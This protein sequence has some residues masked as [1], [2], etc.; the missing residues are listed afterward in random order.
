MIRLATHPALAAHRPQIML[1]TPP[2]ID[3]RL[4]EICDREKGINVTRRTAVNTAR[5]AQTVRD[6]G[7]ELDLPVLDIWS[8]FMK[9]A[10]WKKGDILPGSKSIDQNPVLVNLMHD[11]L[12]FTPDGYKILFKEFMSLVRTVLPDLEP[13]KIPF[14]LPPWDDADA[15]IE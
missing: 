12:H 3:E 14:V 4:C 9:E 8:A 7:N 2:P 5:Y 11:G 10:G 15:W 6:I 1:V 13:E